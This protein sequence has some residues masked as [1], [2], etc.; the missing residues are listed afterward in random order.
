MS[1]K[2]KKTIA[3]ALREGAQATRR[4]GSKPERAGIIRL[5]G[6]GAPAKK[7]YTTGKAGGIRANS[8]FK[9]SSHQDYQGE[10][11]QIKYGA[12]RV[13]QAGDTARAYAEYRRNKEFEERLEEIRN[14]RRR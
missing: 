6:N 7:Y 13:R 11:G 14:G 3:E 9:A 1:S 12:S 10:A 2:K 8:D 4:A 5:K